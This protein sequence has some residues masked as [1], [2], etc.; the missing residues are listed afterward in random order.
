MHFCLASHQQRWQRVINLGL[1][2]HQSSLLCGGNPSW[3]GWPPPLRRRLKLI[4]AVE[5][6]NWSAV[7]SEQT[8]ETLPSE[9]NGASGEATAGGDGAAQEAA[10]GQQQQQ[11]PVGS[12]CKRGVRE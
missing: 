10:A 4:Q 2:G 7:V 3:I 8:A 9:N 1:R 5:G 12:L 11:A 6:D